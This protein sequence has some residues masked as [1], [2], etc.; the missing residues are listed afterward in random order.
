MR[1][2]ECQLTTKKITQILNFPAPQLPTLLRTWKTTLSSLVPEL[3]TLIST[4]QSSDQV[5]ETQKTLAVDQLSM[6]RSKLTLALGQPNESEARNVLCGTGPTDG[7]SQLLF[8]LAKLLDGLG[9]GE[10]IRAV[11]GALGLCV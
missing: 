11:S 4:V 3:T 5:P 10:V 1:V 6:L 9:L 7:L 8:G 2:R